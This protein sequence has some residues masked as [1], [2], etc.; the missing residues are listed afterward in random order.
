[1]ADKYPDSPNPDQKDDSSSDSDEASIIIRLEFICQSDSCESR[2]H[3][4]SPL[5]SSICLVNVN[6]GS[7]RKHAQIEEELRNIF[8]DGI[9]DL[10]QKLEDAEYADHKLASV[11]L[12][13]KDTKLYTNGDIDKA[14]HYLRRRGWQGEL[15]AKCKMELR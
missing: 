4:Q 15:G 7:D 5:N 12:S 14:L 3:H 8:S 11:E 1:M 6:L 13:L 9:F 2:H 10:K